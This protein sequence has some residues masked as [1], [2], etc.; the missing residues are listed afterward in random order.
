MLYQGP[1]F[2]YVDQ[3]LPIVHTLTPKYLPLLVDIGEG[4]YLFL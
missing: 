2:N 4:I 1:F 3:K